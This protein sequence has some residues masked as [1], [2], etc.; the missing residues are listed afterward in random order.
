MMFRAALLALLLTA[1]PAFAE[2]KGD[3]GTIVLPTGIGETSSD[4]LTSFNP[5]FVET[6]Y[7]QE[8]AWSLYPNLLWINRFSQIDWSRSLASA[9]TTTDNTT[10]TI[11]LHPLHWSDG[12]PLVAADVVYYFSLAKQL[13][14][15]WTGYG[16]G[17][18]P[19]IIQ[20][21]KI[22]NQSQFQITTTH[23][24]NPDWFIYNGIGTL[25]AFPQH[26]WQ[27]YTLD[28]MDQL[29]STPS[30][31]NVVI[32][33]LKIQKLVFGQYA[34]FVP[35]PAWDGPKMHFSQLVFK[36]LRGDGAEMQGV[37]S[38]NTDAAMLAPSLFNFARKIPNT[39]IDVLPADAFVNVINL[40]YQNPADDFFHDVRVR[41]AMEDSIDQTTM[42]NLVFHGEADTAYGAVPDDMTAFLSPA[43][44]AGIYP[45]GYNLAKA[46]ALLAAAG[47]TP[48][49][50]GIMQKHGKRLS[51]S[52]LEPAG[53]DAFVAM[54][55]FVQSQF[56]K[57][58][59]EMKI[60]ATD[61]NQMLALMSGQPLR[62]DAADSGAPV[63][64][65]P[66]GEGELQTGAFQNFA[67]YSDPKM[68]QLIEKNV[69]NPGLQNLFDYETYVSAQQPLIYYAIQLPTVL[70]ANR[71]HGMTEFVDPAGQF[72][73]DQLYCTPG[74]AK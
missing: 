48:G 24:V 29:Q 41:Q 18:L 35:N 45:V 12:V 60:H 61:F 32:G 44:R 71:L 55:E 64:N 49:P 74:T 68:D 3:C 57:A 69:N 11:T 6:A 19:Y 70:V 28:Q 65:Y 7:N 34:S 9:V 39:Y 36:F 66:S 47:Y 13:G 25:T 58:G 22:L 51:F 73:P 14:T 16:A 38:G 31:F 50:D 1:T 20:S 27:N 40:N 63:Q 5:L 53:S 56:R 59:I 26:A 30:F 67:H 62:W 23:P 52:L 46:R 21:I 15:N 4:D 17:G 2:Q 37:E 54:D 43:M 72:A 33:P 8:A 10:F 42:V